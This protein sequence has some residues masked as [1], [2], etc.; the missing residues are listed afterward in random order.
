MPVTRVPLTLLS[1]E[2]LD[3]RVKEFV[4]A[5]ELPPQERPRGSLAVGDSI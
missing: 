4:H 1:A 2:L 5:L 3:G